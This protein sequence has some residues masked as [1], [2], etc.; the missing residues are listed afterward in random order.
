MQRV[1]AH[2]GS[3]FILGFVTRYHVH[4][5]YGGRVQA[6]TAQ[7]RASVATWNAVPM[8]HHTTWSY[9]PPYRRCTPLPT[10]RSPMSTWER[11]IATSKAILGK[12]ESHS[13]FRRYC[14]LKWP[15]PSARKHDQ[16]ATNFLKL[17]P[18]PAGN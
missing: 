5:F 10:L 17:P 16:P 4:R 14:F 11:V 8:L 7:R 13:R 15:P 2:R 12:R 9:E 18:V 6:A 1:H 3:D